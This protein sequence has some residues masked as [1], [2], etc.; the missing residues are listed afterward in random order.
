MKRDIRDLFMEEEK[1]NVKLP[2]NHRQE[3]IE[4]LKNS[5]AD[6][7]K[8][9]K[10]L[11]LKIAASVLLLLSLSIYM[12]KNTDNE[13]SIQTEIAAIEKKYL[14]NIES[15]WQQLKAI[16]ND[17]IL[18]KKYEKKL[19]NFDL[20]YQKISSHL[21]EN[22]NNINILQAL[23]TNLQRR[24]QLVKDIKEHLKELNQKNTSNETIFI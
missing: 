21:D 16:S 12:F 6:T 20:E 2:E 7:S 11:F 23:I 5:S 3:F 17:T 14:Q 4:K 1:T 10:F 18:I 15:E 13:N 9:S 24:L 19:M 22:P 8:S